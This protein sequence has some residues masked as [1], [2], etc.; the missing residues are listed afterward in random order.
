MI[1][2]NQKHKDNSNGEHA[3]RILRELS[4]DGKLTQRGLAKKADISLGKTNY[5]I[6][7]L[8][9]K[10]LVKMKNF[11]ESDRKLTKVSYILTP[12]GFKEKSALILHFLKRKQKEYENLRREWE[13]LERVASEKEAFLGSKQ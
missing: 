6:K 9:K 3:L 7:E 11:Y 2:Q 12:Q 5:L 1:E 8:T 10:G 13:N 4:C